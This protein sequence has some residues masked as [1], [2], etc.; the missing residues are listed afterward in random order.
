MPLLAG[1]SQVHRF[2]WSHIWQDLTVPGAHRYLD[3]LP[4]LSPDEYHVLT[5]RLASTDLERG[6]LSSLPPF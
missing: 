3:L 4:L 2:L 5:K 6:T 1:S